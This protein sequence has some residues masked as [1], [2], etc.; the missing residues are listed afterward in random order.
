MTM[1]SR[2]LFSLI[3]VFAV[4][5]Y[6]FVGYSSNVTEPSA[7]GSMFQPPPSQSGW[8]DKFYTGAMCTEYDYQNSYKNLDSLGLTLWQQ[9]VGGEYNSSDK[10]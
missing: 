1:K 6:L 4:L 3:L 10:R 5:F 9:Y 7:E 8:G 2:I